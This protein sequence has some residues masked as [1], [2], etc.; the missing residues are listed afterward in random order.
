MGSRFQKEGIRISFSFLSITFSFYFL[1]IKG[2]RTYNTSQLMDI[3]GFK[4]GMF[5]VA[6]FGY[7]WANS[8]NFWKRS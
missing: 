6:N 7:G 2:S 4:H 1:L 8:A 3:I 5:G